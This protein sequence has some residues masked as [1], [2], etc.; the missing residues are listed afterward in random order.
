MRKIVIL[1]FLFVSVFINAQEYKFNIYSQEEGL[2]QPYVYD[3]IQT[4]NGFLYVAT[5]DGLATFGG[6]RF[7]KFTKRVG[8]AE[9]FCSALFSDSEKRI[10]IGHFEGGVTCYEKGQFRKI[11]TGDIQP[12]KIV[13]LAE[14]PQ[15]TIYFVNAAGSIYTIKNDKVA[16]FIVEELPPVSRLRIKDNIMY[17]ASQEGLLAIDLA[18][19]SKSY[20]AI[21][22][23]KDKNVTCIEFSKSGEIIAGIDG[24]GVEI[25]RR[26]GKNFSSFKTFSSEFKSKR[27]NVKDVC[28]K[29][30]SELWVSL[31]GEGLSVLKFSNNTYQIEKQLT[32]GEKNGLNSS[33]VS[34][35]FVDKEDNLWIGTIGGGLSQFMSDRFEL[36]NKNN[37]LKFDNIISVAVDD[38]NFVYVT[39]ESQLY[40]FNPKDSSNVLVNVV[41]SNSEEQIKCSYINKLNNELWI[42]TTSNLFIFDI[43]GGK[44]K[45]KFQFNEFKERSINYITKDN[46]GQTL[47]CTTEGLFYLNDKNQVVKVF[48][49]DEGAPHNNFNS[50]F[51]DQLD[52]YWI[53]SPQTPLYHLYN[54]EITLEKDLDSSTSFKFNCATIDK[55]DLVWF[56]TEGDGVFS[57]GKKRKPNYQRFTT[58]KGLSSDFIYG[59]IATNNGDII[60]CHKNGISIKYASLKTF[61]AINK[62][63]GLPANTINSNAIFKD[64][65][66]YIWLGSTE[67]L[68]KYS[69]MQDKIN[70]IPPTLSFISIAIN[71]S[72]LN[73]SDTLYEF[74]Y[75]KYELAMEV[76]GVSLSNSKGVEYK[77]MLEGLED[78]WRTSNDREITYPGLTDGTY[79]FK[80][81][82]RNADGFETFKELSFTIIINQPYWKSIW[83]YVVIVSVLIV[84]LVLFFRARTRKLKQEKIRLEQ[85]VTEKTKELVV[86]KERVE[87]ANELLHE[88]NRDITDSIT[89]AKRIQNAVLP[90]QDDVLKNL[91]LFVLFKPRDIVSGDFYWYHATANYLYVAVVDCTGHGVPGAFM[92]LLGSTYLD[93]VMIERKEPAPSEVLRE[94]DKKINSAFK[95]SNPD[96]KIGDGMDMCICRIN[97]DKKEIVIA[98]ANRPVYYVRDNTLQETKAN[99][100]S[101]GGYFEG[102]D[103]AFTEISYEIQNGDAFY[104]FSDGY[105]DQFGGEKN[106]RFSTKRMRT[107]FTEINMLPVNEQR[108][109]LDVEFEAWRGENEQ[110]DDVCVIG[111]KF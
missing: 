46:L 28:F 68:I 62:N 80:I 38:S 3:I 22:N 93:Q 25:I 13:A 2:P 87:K 85:M 33:F 109:K 16:P 76:I 111:I 43:K 20:N 4:Q 5:G 107:I 42:G 108:D 105:G 11:N 60:T 7:N 32:I 54:G 6:H 92:S 66:G 12:A 37:F 88:K 110:I 23:T 97:R 72:V 65:N 101:I 77:Y 44:P 75:G 15:K 70:S 84:S 18:G 90:N 86:E 36:F 74:P 51:I 52:K 103:K 47:V 57:Y 17:V 78:K 95:Q 10:W 79:R 8:L 41:P 98:S 45:L 106:R 56:G 30:G 31:N 35:L 73:V 50:V 71:D 24:E 100:Y 64:K 29:N 55:N 102:A 99:V 49:T 26:E 69:P 53:F 21:G 58:N 9:N 81:I 14:G 48:N 104:M 63:S 61:R 89:Y 94:L 39:N 1:L 40:S 67:G 96:Q 91:N 34:K 59:I 27:L 83:F 19:G 82:A